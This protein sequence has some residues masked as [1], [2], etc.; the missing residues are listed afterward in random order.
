MNISTNR[1]QYVPVPV[2][3]DIL[4]FVISTEHARFTCSVK[5]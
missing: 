2:R 5:G 1:N 3:G 4:D